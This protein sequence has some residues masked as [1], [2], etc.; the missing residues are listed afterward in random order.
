M[1]TLNESSTISPLEAQT[2]VPK[3]RPAAS[4]FPSADEFFANPLAAIRRM[5]EDIDRL[6]SQGVAPGTETS[7]YAAGEP[8]AWRPA[9]ETKQQG[10]L[11][12]VSADLPG[13]KGEDVRVEVNQS[14]LVIQGERRQETTGAEGLVHRTERR[15]GRFYRTISLPAGAN[16]D[17]A[18]A[19]F[20]DGVLE[21]SIPM[22]QT[23]SELRQIPIA[24]GV[25]VTAG[26]G[27]RDDDVSL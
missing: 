24:G 25:A 26:N 14:A 21:V 18:S 16:P 17:Q 8:E 22:S 13:L 19:T 3:S 5:H 20:H 23:Q 6:F 1:S 15:Y 10:N 7:R 4:Y 2:A 12:I 11:L 27:H 9:I